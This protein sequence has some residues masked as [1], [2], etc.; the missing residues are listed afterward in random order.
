MIEPWPS[1]E[2]L[3][4]WQQRAFLK[5]NNQQTPNFLVVATPGAGKTKLALRVAHHELSSGRAERIV[6]IVPTEHLKRQWSGDAAQ[7]GL[8]FNY[9][10]GNG[11]GGLAADYHG[12]CLTFAQVGSNPLAARLLCDR[13]TFVIIDEIHHAGREKPWGDGLASAFGDVYRRLSLSGT[14]FRSDNNPI[15]FVTYGED[16]RSRADFPYSYADALR[17]GICRV[18]FF[19][20]FEGNMKWYSR[21]QDREATFRDELSEAESARRLRTALDPG[22]EWIRT[23][24]RDADAKL[25]EVRQ[26]HP[27]AGGLILAIDRAH[28]FALA[29][30]FH[31]TLGYRPPVVTAEDA[32]GRPNPN[33]SAEIE[34]FRESGARWIIAVKMISEGVNL[35]RLRVG[36]Y[37]TNVQAPLFFRQAVGRVVRVTD[38]DGDDQSAYW[39]IPRD[40]KIVGYAQEIKEE[41]DHQLKEEIERETKAR[42]STESG[43][44]KSSSIFV[45]ISSTGQ[46]DDVVV[47]EHLLSQAE[48]ARADGLRQ[49]HGINVP[50]EKIAAL[51][52]D[53]SGP[54]TVTVTA[55][56]NRPTQTK[57][58]QKKDLRKLLRSLAARIVA[59]SDN[60][61]AFKDIF[62]ALIRRDGVDTE[63]ATIPQLKDRTRH[64]EEWLRSLADGG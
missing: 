51:I 59:V 45:A 43:D 44:D 49:K 18:V 47:D 26:S 32:E 56:V 22:G 4:K 55:T 58:D 36:I 2:E 62:T 27:K 10:W 30:K 17:D 41:R 11:A 16:G 5:F 31:E 20:S 29:K 60:R 54:P 6:V 35:P 24:F 15:P 23:V 13:P 39:F 52:R 42:D 64:L 9:E 48:I 21:G 46:A 40:P 25:T 50:V 3:R 38:D 34:A 14:P 37:A 7:F 12:A 1:G 53:L 57:T 63:Q 28:A 8:H 33:A 61:I 19:P